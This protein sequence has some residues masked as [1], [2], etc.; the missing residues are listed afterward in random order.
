[1][2]DALTPE[3]ASIIAGVP[4]EQLKRWAWDRVGP[5]NIGTRYNPKYTEEDLKAWRDAN[6]NNSRQRLAS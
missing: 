1:M 5:R 2:N 3:Q 4:A 6:G